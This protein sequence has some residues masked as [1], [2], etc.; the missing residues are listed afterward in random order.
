[1]VDYQNVLWLSNA[2]LQASIVIL[3]VV[4]AFVTFFLA[5]TWSHLQKAK[6]LEQ[7]ELNAIDNGRSLVKH[8]IRAY[9]P[10]IMKV[11]ESWFDKKPEDME[12][13]VGVVSKHPVVSR[14]NARQRLLLFVFGPRFFIEF[15]PSFTFV[16]GLFV[17]ILILARKWVY[18]IFLWLT[19]CVLTGMPIGLVRKDEFSFPLISPPLFFFALFRSSPV[20]KAFKERGISELK[21]GR[22]GSIKLKAS[23]PQTNRKH[24]KPEIIQW[25]ILHEVSKLF[26][27]KL[28]FP[29]QLDFMKQFK[30]SSPPVRLYPSIEHELFRK[31]KEGNIPDKFKSDLCAI[32]K[33]YNE[34]NKKDVD[35]FVDEID[36]YHSEHSRLS[37]FLKRPGRVFL[38]VIVGLLSAFCTAAALLSILAISRAS[39]AELVTK[40][41][42]Q[43]AMAFLISAVIGLLIVVAL[44]LKSI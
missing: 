38:K 17:F 34:K 4:A 33:K 2:V 39:S 35:K 16:I 10:E 36:D 25:A 26:P 41:L 37:T 8:L 31:A 44:M 23:D 22:V 27:S 20:V 12:K 21:I 43:I 24:L 3:T 28:L 5:F 18:L 30:V 9:K 42:S 14:I 6:E 1:M 11:Y 19:F 40:N 29:L 7:K 15:L 13:F 32:F